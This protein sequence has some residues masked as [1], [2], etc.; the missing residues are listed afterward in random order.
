MVWALHRLDLR[1][2]TFGLSWGNFVHK[3]RFLRIFSIFCIFDL[4][5]I[6]Y[7]LSV[8]LDAMSNCSRRSTSWGVLKD[9][10][11]LR[12]AHVHGAEQP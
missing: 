7:R 6:L 2:D 1:G 5:C 12:K 10:G 11:L 3:I 8:D 9:F 4:L